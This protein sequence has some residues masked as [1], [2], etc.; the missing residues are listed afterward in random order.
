MQDLIDPPAQDPFVIG[1]DQSKDENQDDDL[2]VEAGKEVE[3]G[4]GHIV[5]AAADKLVGVD[6][7]LELRRNVG[8]AFRQM[9]VIDQLQDQV[10][11]LI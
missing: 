2:V 3:P 10:C 8:S 1:V 7:A 6:G 11:A 5:V 4:L 9:A